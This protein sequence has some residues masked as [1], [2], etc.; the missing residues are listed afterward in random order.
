L[1]NLVSTLTAPTPLLGTQAPART[2]ATAGV[3]RSRQTAS[4]VRDT[5]TMTAVRGHAADIRALSA[6]NG[7]AQAGA[8]L[9]QVA[10]RGLGEIDD[11]LVKM[12]D[13]AEQASS[14]IA[15][16]SHRERAILNVEFQELLTEIDR[17]ADETQFNGIQVLKGTTIFEES[18]VT[19]T[20]HSAITDLG[21][22]IEVDDGF[23]NFVIATSPSGVSDGDRIRIEYSKQTDLFTI[24]NATTG[25]NTTVAAPASAPQP[26][27]TID[28][29]VSAF[30]LTFQVNSNF[31]PNQNNKA[32]GGNPGQNEFVVSL[33]TTSTTTIV[34]SR[35]MELSF[36][37]G[38]G[39]A[40]RDKI[41]IVLAAAT[42]ADLDSNLASDD[43]ASAAGA[44][45]ALANVTNA[46][47]ALNKAQAS[48][49][50]DKIRF[51]AAGRNLASHT[52]TLTDLKTD[53]LERLVRISTTDGLT[54]RV[55]EQFSSQARPPMAGRMSSAMLDLL[56]SAGPQPLV[57]P[58]APTSAQTP[59][60]TQNQPETGFTAYRQAHQPTQSEPYTPVDVKA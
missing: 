51:Q 57:L 59:G 30:S 50:G 11:A 49:D 24:T 34:T 26:G 29:A 52:N 5:F 13:L 1:L 60:N 41:E 43:I 2:S 40:D 16:L 17:I 10:D 22:K 36:R 47:G 20:H 25:Q 8:S 56:L 19:V 58:E 45:L 46:I 44:E 33:T 28:V 38:T 14:T 9:L 23:E 32:P 37:V 18:F 12:K 21:S 54:N 4:P 55:S 53:R 15:P 7:N 39:T 42:V 6:A 48:I 35:A 27:E 3:L 31:N